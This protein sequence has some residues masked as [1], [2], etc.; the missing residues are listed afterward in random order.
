MINSITLQIGGMMCVRCAGAV[1][2]ALKSVDGVK[3]VTVSYANE[4]AE[5]SF[6]TD[7]TSRKKLEKAIKAAGYTVVED[8]AAFRRREK[9]ELTTLFVIS[10]VLSVPFMLMMVLMFSA[11]N[12]HLTHILHNGWL[13]LLFATPVQIIVGWRFY[14]GAFLS[15]K[16]HSPNMDMLIALGTTAA[17]GYSLYNMFTDSG[18]L[19]FESSAMVITM[20]LLGKLLETRARSK[21]SAAV[22]ML[23]NLQPPVATVVRNGEETVIPTAEIEEGDILI[24]HPGESISADGEVASGYS[25]VDESMLT[26]ESMP[27]NKEANSKVFGGTVNGAGLL[28]VRVENAGSKTVLSG[29][30]RLVEQ[31]QSSKAKIQ[32]T[33]DKVAAVFVPVVI[34][35]SALTLVLTLAVLRQPSEAVSRA[36]AVLVV[37]CPCSLGLATPTALMVGTGRAASMGVLI[38]SADALETA[39]KIQ[40]VILDKTGT[41]TE[42]KPSIT[43]L[44]TFDYSEDE[45]LQLAASAEQYSEH[46]VA[47]AICGGFKGELLSSDNFTS[48]TGKGIYA[49]V[50]GKKVFLGNKLIMSEQNVDFGFDTSDLENEG[51][52]VMLMA[53]DGKAAA[54][55]AVADPV[56]ESSASAVSELHSLGIEV[57]MVTGDNSRTANAIA[58]QIGI[59]KVTAEVLPDGKVL[60][61]QKAKETGKTVA[62][63]GDGINDAPALASADIG[64]A[65][66]SG[67]DIAMESGDVV[68]VGANIASLPTAIRLSKATMRKIRQNLFWA[69]FYNCIGIPIAALGLL[70]PVFAGAAMAFSSVTVVT[71]SLLLRKS[72]IQNKG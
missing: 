34:G 10:A 23:M 39:C 3:S 24:I 71:N 46:P 15:L 2:H 59:D 45:I 29:I 25:A 68:L 7:E 65:M 69:F 12:A 8:K 19:Y 5:I 60:A 56:R 22:E 51:K 14:K 33:A 70:S 11:P 43:D 50:D 48:I 61:V 20:V 37:A 18:H 64:F 38:K 28:T 4:R 26:G 35:I 32:K 16:N 55:I 30:I 58:K 63:V 13:Q 62:M 57:Q 72:N 42:G 66:G 40:S 31:A 49:E 54:V 17:Y 6:D 9:R 36:V 53:V 41:V 27:V 67:T 1:E 52:T 44:K 21:T 47:K